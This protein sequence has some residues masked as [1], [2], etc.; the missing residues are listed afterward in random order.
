MS[1][2]NFASML[3]ATFVAMSFLSPSLSQA[4]TNTPLK[5]KTPDT[6]AD[7]KDLSPAAKPAESAP[8]AKA[9]VKFEESSEPSASEFGSPSQRRLRQHGLGLG[10]GQTF[11][12]G[13]YGKY[14]Q[15]K[16]TADLLYS[17]AASHSFDL[18]LDAHLSTHKDNSEEMKLMG[19][20]GS[21]KG[22]MVEYDNF[23][24]YF[25]A[26]LGFYAPQA[27][28]DGSGK[29]SRKLTFGTNFGGG[30]DLRLNESYVIG[31]MAQMHWPF[32]VQQDEGSDLKGYYMK[33]LLTGMYLF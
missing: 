23:S 14:G 32:K 16:I 31:V 33:L 25:L 6:S 19:L 24:P 28:R 22:R 9:P 29:T 20:V 1:K 5:V 13:N 2:S 18:L 30:M 3:M 21:F 26:G 11:L 27:D 15:D 4:Q 12:F 8:K 10:I 17:Y 7:F